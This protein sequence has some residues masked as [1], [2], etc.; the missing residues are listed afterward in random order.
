M[1]VRVLSAR[2]LLMVLLAGCTSNRVIPEELEPQV[3]RN[4]SFSELKDAPDSYRG[5]LVVLGGEVLSAKRLKDGTQLEILQLPLESGEPTGQRQDSQGRFLA[6]QR[7]FLDPAT[8]P[9][10]Q[11]ITVVGEVQGATV[12]RLDD[13]EYR[14]PTLEAKHMKF[15]DQSPGYARRPGPWW[16]IFGGVGFGGGGSRSGVGV[17]VGF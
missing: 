2:L 1:I 8:V 17:G 7:E 14:Y 13:T 10:G 5:R 9:D 16:S 6:I 3:D 12:Q 11:R 4:V 15:W